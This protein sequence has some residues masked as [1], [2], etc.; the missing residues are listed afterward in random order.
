MP[1]P[2]P[3]YTLWQL[4]AYMLKLGACGFGGSLALVGYMHRDLVQRRGWISEAQYKEG[5]AIT[6]LV[7][8]PMSAQLAMVVGHAHYGA[9][10][11][12]LAGLAF[13]LPS[14]LLVVAL[15][16]AYT[17]F[18]GFAW[19]QAMFYGVGAA[20]VGTIAVSAKRLT[21][22]NIGRD[23]LL[24]TIHALL[25]LATILGRTDT[26]WLYVAA[27]LAVWWHRAPPRLASNGSLHGFGLLSLP[28]VPALVGAADLAVLVQL[29][30]FFAKVGALAV[31]SGLSIVPFLHDGVVAQWH[32]ISERQFVDAIAI[33]MITPGP[34]VIAVAFIGYLVAGLSGAAVAALATLVPCYV[35][36]LALAPHFRR[37]GSL[38]GFAAFVDGVAAATIGATCGA[39]VIIGR[40]LV[41]DMPTVLIAAGA[42]G[43]LW[44]FRQVGEPVVVVVAGLLGLWLRGG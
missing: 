30:V 43:L 39:A 9:L 31:G 22:A 33:A 35:L 37:Y 26:V 19:V 44:R 5:M 23:K 25:A 17:R 13:V 32:W 21:V 38:P 41:T 1:K 27:G 40:Q 18:Q 6:Q 12:T 28:S 11:A 24:W 29:G 34:V 3:A 2:M 7:P 20:V 36:T 42:A 15:G 4:V 10:G 16:W 14:F 8:G